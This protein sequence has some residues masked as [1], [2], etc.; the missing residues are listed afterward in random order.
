MPIFCKVYCTRA[1]YL[2]VLDGA[3]V[4][5]VDHGRAEGDAAHATEGHQEALHGAVR[6]GEV[7]RVARGAV[8]EAAHEAERGARRQLRARRALQLALRAALRH[9]HA[10]Q[11]RLVP[12]RHA[13]HRRAVLARQQVLRVALPATFTRL[14][15]VQTSFHAHNIE[16]HR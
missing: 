14:L 7:V 8:V 4:V 3:D 2:E 5:L 12:P 16:R 9:A 10:Q 15:T 13:A 11:L 1:T 6:V